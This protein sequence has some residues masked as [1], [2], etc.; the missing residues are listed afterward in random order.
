[1]V[2]KGHNFDKKGKGHN[3]FFYVKTVFESLTIGHGLFSNTD[4]LP[5]RK[6]GNSASSSGPEVNGLAGHA[7][8][9]VVHHK[10]SSATLDGWLV[11]TGWRSMFSSF[12]SVHV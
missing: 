10:C 3:L 5:I 9:F 11:W 6:L 4:Y 7:C 1:V 12:P 8:S 2:G